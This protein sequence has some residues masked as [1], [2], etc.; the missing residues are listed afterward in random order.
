LV[1]EKNRLHKLLDDAGIKGGGVSDIDGVSARQMVEGL[2]AGG[3]AWAAFLVRPGLNKRRQ[4]RPAMDPGSEE[5]WLLAAGRR[6]NLSKRGIDVYCVC[7]R[8]QSDPDL[9]PIIWKQTCP[10]TQPNPP[11]NTTAPASSPRREGPASYSGTVWERRDANCHVGIGSWRLP[12]T[13]CVIFLLRRKHFGTYTEHCAPAAWLEAGIFFNLQFDAQHVGG[14]SI[15]LTEIIMRKSALFFA[16]I[17]VLALLGVSPAS[18]DVEVFNYTGNTF[19]M[20]N[21]TQTGITTNDFVTATVTLDCSGVWTS[22]TPYTFG[23]GVDHITAFALSVGPDGATTYST[24]AAPPNQILAGSFIDFS[25][26]GKVSDWLLGLNASSN[27]CDAIVT[28]ERPNHPVMDEFVGTNEESDTTGGFNSDSQGNWVEVSA[29][30]GPI[31]G[32]G[33]LSYIALVCS[34]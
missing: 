18:A 26:P 7:S 11:D 24:L 34:D 32:S 22:G 28:E 23:T 14:P 16:T 19:T 29:A 13:T 1:A 31:P 12:D 30:P 5:I 21:P 9:G 6:R 8:C 2:I 3:I 10:K 20:A 33:F 15:T 17:A 4:E 27:C 25:A